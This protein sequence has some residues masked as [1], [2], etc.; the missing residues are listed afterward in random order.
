MKFEKIIQS[1]YLYPLWRIGWIEKAFFL[2]CRKFG[3]QEAA[4][5]FLDIWRGHDVSYYQGF[6]DFLQMVASGA[7]FVVPRLGYGTTK[8]IRF[9]EYMEGAKGVLPNNPYHF[10][11]P[12]I[13]PV[14]QADKVLTI[15]APYQHRVSRV[16]LDMEYEWGGA[17]T[18][19]KHWK[20]YRDG[21]NTV[22]P[23]GI[24]TRATWW[25]SRVGTLAAEFGRD[26][27]WVAQYSTALTLIP[28]GAT[29]VYMWQSGSPTYYAGQTSPRI[30][31]DIW[32]TDYNFD[33]EWG[34]VTPPTGEPKMLYGKINA[35]ALNVRTG[36]GASYLQ[37]GTVTKDDHVI[38]TES[39]GGWWHLKE[40]YTDGWTGEPVKLTN[41][42]LI[43]NTANAWCSSA[44][45]LP[46]DPPIVTPPPP[47]AQ[48]VIV[49]VTIS[50]A[51]KTHNTV[52]VWKDGT[53]S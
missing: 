35:T 38:A 29:K 6:I 5:L 21:I 27:F 7:K 39:V 47:V 3:K 24:Y 26:P 28:K 32:N 50:E 23:T 41:G 19:S 44:Y 22:Y 48:E 51:N 37:I 33:A 45:I 8:D 12:E 40:A 10:Y 13:S 17:Y 11:H 15:L 9:D 52:V 49:T 20:T 42:T 1:E 36:N 31:Y 53:Q 30:D 18:D 14:L 43:N 46:V 2:A 4:K 25:D 16:W 34:T